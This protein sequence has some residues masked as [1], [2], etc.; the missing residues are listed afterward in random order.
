MRMPRYFFH[1]KRGQVTVLDQNGVE[2]GGQEEAEEEGKRR[3]QEILTGS[4]HKGG[5]ANKGAVIIA[6]EEWHTVLELP[7]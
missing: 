3:V 2:L 6:D 5:T 4:N 7:F 1:V